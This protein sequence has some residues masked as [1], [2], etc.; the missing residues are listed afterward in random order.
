MQI[1]AERLRSS[2]LASLSHDLRTPLTSLIGLADTA[3]KYWIPEFGAFFIYIATIV[4]LSWRP[5]GLFG[6]AA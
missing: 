3:C 4:V 5:A 1:A 6:R 2:I